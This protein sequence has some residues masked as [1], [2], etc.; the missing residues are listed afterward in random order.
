MRGAARATVVLGVGLVLG[1][2]GI[3]PAVGVPTWVPLIGRSNSTKL[4]PASRVEPPRM[5]PMLSRG[6]AP[7]GDQPPPVDRVVCV[8]NND[9][10]TLYELEEYEAHLLYESKEA[11]PEGAAREAFRKQILDRF[12]EDRLQLQQAE[13]EK[14]AI[15]DLDVSERL[16]EVMKRLNAQNE[17]ELDEKL[18]EQGLSLESAKKRVRNRLLVD[19]VVNRRVRLRVSVTEPEIDRYLEQ[20][21]E[22]L[23]VGLGF[24]ASHILFVPP[25]DSGDDGWEAARRRAEEASAQLLAGAPFAQVASQ[26]S[27]DPSGKDGGRLGKLKRGELAPEIEATILQL[28]PGDVS[29]PFRSGVGYHIFRLDSREVL[30]GEAMSQARGQVRDILFRDKYEA[31]LKEWLGELRQRAIIDVRL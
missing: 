9:A 21:R 6:V 20:N 5:A 2:C 24:E 26:T 10:I 19:R 14:L 12:V 1:G 28:R 17:K 15:D 16:A 4:A 8:V 18:K 3:L 30:T 11:P 29:A 22:K 7:D 31:R 23:E 13:R 25:A 27:D